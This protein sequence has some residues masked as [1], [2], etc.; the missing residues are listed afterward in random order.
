M[1]CEKIK[2]NKAKHWRPARTAYQL[3]RSRSSG[4]RASRRAREKKRTGVICAPLRSKRASERKGAKENQQVRRLAG[5]T[6][7]GHH[8]SRERTGR[9]AQKQQAHSN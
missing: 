1:E 4:A 8:Y 9:P 2:Q 3:G 7:E 6:R 5:Q